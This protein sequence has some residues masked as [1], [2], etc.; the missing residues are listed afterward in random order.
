ML[1]HSLA[2]IEFNAM[3]SYLDTALRFS[4]TIENIQDRCEFLCDMLEVSSQESDHFQLLLQ[5]LGKDGV[6]YGDIPVHS[7]L[8]DNVKR[9]MDH[10]DKRIAVISII[11]E[12][13]GVDAGERL[14]IKLQS[15]QDKQGGII[16][17]KILDEEVDHIRVGY[18]WFKKICE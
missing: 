13:K 5:R 8:V 14:M 15:F 9:S 10:L 16:L 11:Q 17:K 7:A 4:H 18:K 2:H 1:L 12:G 3:K 6:N